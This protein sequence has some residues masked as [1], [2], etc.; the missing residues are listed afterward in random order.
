MLI[1]DAISNTSYNIDFTKFLGTIMGGTSGPGAASGGTPAVGGPG[2]S[3][4]GY[5]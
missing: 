2:A 4:H 5:Y 1:N 3:T